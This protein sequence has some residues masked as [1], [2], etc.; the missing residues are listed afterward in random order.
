MLTAFSFADVSR[1][2]S[3]REILFG[4]LGR[5]PFLRTVVK[6]TAAEA[7]LQ[8]IRVLRL[9]LRLSRKHSALQTSL[10]TVTYLSDLVNRCTELGIQIDALVQYEVAK[11]LWDQGEMGTSIKM[12]QLLERREDLHKQALPLSRPELLA[13]LV[14]NSLMDSNTLN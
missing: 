9:S 4:T 7:Q 14:C 2:L 11:V 8:E 1:I 6:V 3:S 12:L 13:T 5:Q 10:N